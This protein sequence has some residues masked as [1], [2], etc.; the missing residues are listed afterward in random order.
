MKLH[1][2]Y[3]LAAAGVLEE[4]LGQAGPI[5]FRGLGQG[6]RS[7]ICVVLSFPSVGLMPRA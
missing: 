5:P 1:G 4:G 6:L 3:N 7:S 2:P